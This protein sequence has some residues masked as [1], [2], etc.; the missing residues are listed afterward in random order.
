MQIVFVVRDAVNVD[1]TK[2]NTL[3]AY[4]PIRRPAVPKSSLITV[5]IE[6]SN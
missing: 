5:N 1:R 3:L 6:P 4:G 2:K